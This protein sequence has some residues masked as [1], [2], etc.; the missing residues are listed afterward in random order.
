M[1]PD[2]GRQPLPHT[3]DKGASTRRTKDERKED[4]TAVSDP[5]ATRTQHNASRRR[6]VVSPN[7]HLPAFRPTRLK[8]ERPKSPST[9]NSLREHKRRCTGSAPGGLGSPHLLESLQMD[10]QERE[11]QTSQVTT[12]ARP[13]TGHGFLSTD[14]K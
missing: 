5:H 2:Q 10:V 8:E 7:R 3:P 12:M 1:S 11:H 6:S 9:W 4:V 14:P 13:A